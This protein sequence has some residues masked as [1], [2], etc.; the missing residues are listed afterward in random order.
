M[1]V[2]KTGKPTETG[3]YIV[4]VRSCGMVKNEV[5]YYS[6]YMKTWR[7]YPDRVIKWTEIPEDTEEKK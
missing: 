6:D 1:S 4:K 5:D 7:W 3:E 2:W